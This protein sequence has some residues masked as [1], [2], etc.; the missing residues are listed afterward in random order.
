MKLR[1]FLS[2]AILLP[3]IV[4]IS[5]CAQQAPAPP[6]ST[7]LTVAPAPDSKPAQTLQPTQPPPVTTLSPAPPEFK[8]EWI[9]DAGIR[10]SD[11]SVP[12]IYRLKDGRFRLY[13]C[14]AGGI[15]SAI[16]SDGLNFERES[17]VRIAPAGGPGSPESIVCDATMVEL[18]DGRVRM[19]YKGA[20][21][22]GGPGEALHKV[23]SAI[24]SDGLSFQKE[25]MRID[26]E[27][28]GDRGWASVPEA[29][30]LPDGRIRI[31]YVSGDFEAQG[32]IM[33]AISQDG[34]NFQKESGARVKTLVDPAVAM[35]DGKYL[36]LAVVL[37]PPPNAPQRQELPVGIYSLVSDDGL[38]FGSP[39]PVLQ[40]AGVYDP[41]IVQLSSD[42]YRVFYGKDI[43]TPGRPNIVTVS[44]TGRL[45][46]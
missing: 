6:D 8:F 22:A 35:P 38:N 16:S 18:P 15:L 14:G 44:I 25:G 30:K 24:S 29:I 12:Y 39:Q 1:Y 3:S 36:L 21:G 46:Q 13:Y 40:E 33:S 5:G 10:V 20:N 4:F 19:Y 23:F 34:L 32:G 45:R 26:S 42:T 27:K 9:K 37:P 31:Y 7:P 28:T 41:S 43:G 2:L 11:G 17:G